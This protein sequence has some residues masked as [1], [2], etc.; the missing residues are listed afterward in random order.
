MTTEKVLTQR[1]SGAQD[2]RYET[3]ITDEFLR[4]ELINAATK[5]EQLIAD[6]KI[7]EHTKLVSNR[8]WGL[9]I[10]T[11][12]KEVGVD[13]PIVFTF[14]YRINRVK[15]KAWA[16]E[17]AHLLGGPCL[18]F[19][20]RGMGFVVFGPGPTETHRTL[21]NIAL[22]D[23]KN[24]YYKENLVDETLTITVH[25]NIVSNHDWLIKGAFK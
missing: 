2:Y 10:H 15:I 12:Y 16:E 8:P 18:I 3:L 1:Y 11:T 19:T 6:D 13:K 9:M 22:D 24:S 5:L 20:D 25:R 7:N 23:E 14:K 4:K 21:C 17:N